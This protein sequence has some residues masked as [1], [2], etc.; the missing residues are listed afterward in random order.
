MDRVVAFFSILMTLGFWVCLLTL[1]V[2]ALMK[3]EESAGMK[4]QK[5]IEAEYNALRQEEW[6]KMWKSQEQVMTNDR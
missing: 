1:V 3:D 2:L 5:N 4:R 6:K